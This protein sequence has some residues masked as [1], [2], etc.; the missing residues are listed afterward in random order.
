MWKAVA[1]Y[2]HLFERGTSLETVILSQRIEIKREEMPEGVPSTQLWDGDHS[3]FIIDIRL[4]D[5]DYRRAVY[6]ELW[7]HFS[8]AV[9]ET[10][11]DHPR[12]HD[13]NARV[14]AE[15]CLQLHGHSVPPIGG[16]N[17]LI[18]EI[19]KTLEFS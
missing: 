10:S 19:D 3:I 18:Q 13:Y 1:L 12:V 14:F 8:P 9:P 15:I 6:H 7:H 17:L 16:L 11:P 5:T 4:H 2:K